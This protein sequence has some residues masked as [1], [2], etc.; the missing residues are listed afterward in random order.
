MAAGGNVRMTVAS[1]VPGL[2]LTNGL[3]GKPRCDKGQ[4][5][6]PLASQSA[7][8]HVDIRLSGDGAYEATVFLEGERAEQVGALALAG[9]RS[10]SGG[11]RMTRKG[12]L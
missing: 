2:D 1:N 6:I 10:V 12:R 5:L 11:Y 8:E 9:F 4:L 3:L 7:M